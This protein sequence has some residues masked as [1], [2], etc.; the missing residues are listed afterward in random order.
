MLI[1]LRKNKG[2][3]EMVNFYFIKGLMRMSNLEKRIIILNNYSKRVLKELKETKNQ[4]K[5]DVIIDKYMDNYDDL[6]I[7][8]NLH[9]Y[10]S[11]DKYWKSIIRFWSPEPSSI[12]SEYFN[13]DY[14]T[15]F[16]LIREEGNGYSLEAIDVINS[17]LEKYRNYTLNLYNHDQLLA[18]DEFCFKKFLH[19]YSIAI[20]IFGLHEEMCCKRSFNRF[21]D[22]GYKEIKMVDK[23]YVNNDE[24]E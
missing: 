4:K 22:S 5:R 2:G 11:D 24:E 8:F 6:I 13:N 18:L 17:D 15:Y 9:R 21:I 16:K 19:E 23:I 12:I 7:S 1:P 14:F 10:F 20:N 3:K